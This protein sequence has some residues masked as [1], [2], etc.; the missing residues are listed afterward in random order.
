MNE[1]NRSNTFQTKF[2]LWFPLFKS[3]EILNE[4]EKGVSLVTLVIFTLRFNAESKVKWFL[5]KVFSI[6]SQI[7]AVFADIF[8][9]EL[10]KYD[11]SFTD[12]CGNQT[13]KLQTVL[14]SFSH[15]F[16]KH[17]RGNFVCCCKISSE[18][19]STNPP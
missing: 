7:C 16:F 18:T 3:D 4:L 1:E 12:M 6:L 8:P 5:A 10:L 17:F 9:S 19:R 13:N 2:R 14:T 11:S 15:Y